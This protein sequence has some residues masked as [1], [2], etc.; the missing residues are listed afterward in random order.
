MKNEQV[1]EWAKQMQAFGTRAKLT[2]SK[3]DDAAWHENF[4]NQLADEREAAV[5]RTLSQFTDLLV[6]VKDEDSKKA[7]AQTI[8]NVAVKEGNLDFGPVPAE[9]LKSPEELISLAEEFARVK[10]DLDDLAQKILAAL[11]DLP[12]DDSDSSDA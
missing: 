2:E 1:K 3:L 11:K 12:Q 4:A 7:L 10:P 6:T 5:T 8:I 9:E